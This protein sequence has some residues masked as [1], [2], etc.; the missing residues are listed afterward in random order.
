M[1]LHAVGSEACKEHRRS[2]LQSITVK[3]HGAHA[4]SRLRRDKYTHE[5]VRISTFNLR[6]KHKLHLPALS[7]IPLK[8]KEQG[9]EGERTGLDESDVDIFRYEIRKKERTKR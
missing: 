6:L 3:M 1:N 5:L 4:C 7:H 8:A 9:K 2:V